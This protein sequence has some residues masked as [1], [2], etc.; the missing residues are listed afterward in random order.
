MKIT[1]H[2]AFFREINE[3]DSFQLK[4]MPTKP[5]FNFPYLKLQ[6]KSFEIFGAAFVSAEGGVGA[7][8]MS[9]V[10]RDKISLIFV[11][12][13]F[14][15]Y[16]SG[17]CTSQLPISYFLPTEF[18]PTDELQY[19]HQYSHH[20]LPPALKSNKIQPFIKKIICNFFGR[21]CLLHLGFKQA[22]M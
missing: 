13:G 14:C 18:P 9:W 3:R 10:L 8:P 15:C 11:G 21:S 4:K 20:C 22:L 16:S 19:S 5:A 6:S 1:F 2:L 12:A 7:L 17:R